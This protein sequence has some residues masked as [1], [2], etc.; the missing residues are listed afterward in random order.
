MVS[1]STSLA[2]E[3]LKK[4]LIDIN[5]NDLGFN[6]GLVDD[7]NLFNWSV[8]FTGTEGTIYEGGFF[9]AT[10]KFPE[11]YPQNPPEMKFLT[12]MW[13]PNSTFLI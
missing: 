9:R 7:S 3:L 12:Q 5:N 2:K 6:V 1:K 11:D 10:L 13:H 8:F 4:Q